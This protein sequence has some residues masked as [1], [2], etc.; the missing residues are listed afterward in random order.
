MLIVVNLHEFYFVVFYYKIFFR[1]VI[2]NY[3]IFVMTCD[4]SE[5][6]RLSDTRVPTNPPLPTCVV[7]G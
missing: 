4:G 7:F 2:S 6:V 3:F 5:S 1:V